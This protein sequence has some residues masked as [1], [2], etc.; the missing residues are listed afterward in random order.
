MRKPTALS[1]M[2]SRIATLLPAV[3]HPTDQ[4]RGAL[5]SG[6][7]APASLALRPRSAHSISPQPSAPLAAA[8][9]L[10]VL[11]PYILVI[12]A[13]CSYYVVIAPLLLG[14]TD[15][16]WHLAA[17]DL[18]RSQGS[19][20]AHDPWSFTAGQ[21]PWINHSWLWDVVASLLFQYV[22]TPA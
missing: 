10:A 9:I 12:A 17:G 19:V 21:T 13:T 22:S 20:P 14:H 2:L 5:I 16:G 15:L 4:R 8:P 1:A 6:R 7:C 18:I 3:A 11:G